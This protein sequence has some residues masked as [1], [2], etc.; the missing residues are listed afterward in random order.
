MAIFNTLLTQIAET[1]P[2]YLLGIVAFVCFY[3]IASFVSKILQNRLRKQLADKI[4]SHLIS[5]ITHWI[6]VLLGLILAMR[7][8]GLADI[9]TS[10]L[11]GAGVSAFLIGFAFKDIAENFLAGIMLAFNRPFNI[12]DTIKTGDILGSVVELDLRNTHLKTFDGKEVYIPNARIISEPLFNSSKNDF[13]RFDFSIAIEYKEDIEKTE[14]IIT[15]RLKKITEISTDK[16]T[17]VSVQ[18]FSPIGTHLQIFFW[19]NKKT[20]SKSIGDINRKAQS[21]VKNALIENNINIPQSFIE[22]P[23]KNDLQ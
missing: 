14:K 6:M 21:E 1:L 17:R 16:K 7:I 15:E 18:S 19:I 3:I 23:E 9:A 20:T 22:K 13:I 2:N 5:R 10:L 11:A 12:G 4:L 8:A